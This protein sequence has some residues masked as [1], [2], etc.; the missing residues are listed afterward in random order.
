MKCI[1]CAL[2]VCVVSVSIGHTQGLTSE[3]R[4]FYLGYVEPSFVRQTFANTTNA[5]YGVYALV[6]SYDDAQVTVSYFDQNGSEH[7][8]GTYQIAKRRS[9]QIPLDLSKM[10]M[11]LP[12]EVAEYKACHLSAN[13][14]IAVTYFSTGACAG[15]SYL[16][17]TTAA[18]GKT[19]VIQSYRDN[20]DGIG[21]VMTHEPSAGYF[22]VV[23][24]FD[25]THVQII[26]SSTTAGGHAGVNC[27]N[28]ASGT[29]RP[30]TVSLS[31]C[32]CYLVRGALDGSDCDLSN[33]VVIADKPVAV[34]AG[35]ENV[36]TDGSDPNPGGKHLLDARDFMIEE[37]LPVEYWDT[38]GYIS[39]PFIDSQAPFNAGEG[40]EYRFFTG[41]IKELGSGGPGGSNV[42]INN[43]IRDYNGIGEYQIPPPQ[44]INWMSPID[45]Y[46]T[47]GTK[48]GVAMYDQRMHGGGAPYP[49]PSQLTIIPKSRWKSSYLF[50]VPNNPFEVL[51]GYY[52]NLI[53][54]RSDFSNR[55]LL[56]SINGGKLTP[57]PAGLATKKIYSVIPEFPEL[58]GY[59]FAIGPGS[60]YITADTGAVQPFM[61]YA[62]GNRA[63]DSDNNLGDM[64]SDDFFFSYASPSG[65][66]MHGDSNERLSVTVDSLCARWHLCIHDSRSKN[67][68]IK[69]IEIVDDI[70]GNRIKPGYQY[71]NVRFDAS[72]DPNGTRE[73]A[74]TGNDSVYCLDV[75]ISNPFDSA[76]A[77]IYIV[78]NEGNGRLI[79][80]HYKKPNITIGVVPNYP[81]QRDSIV[82]PPTRS[83]ESSCAT[84]S[85][86]NSGKP[87]EP[88][89]EVDNVTLL[90]SDGNYSITSIKPAL[91]VMLAPGDTLAV[92]VC[93]HPQNISTR[94]DS[95]P[96]YVDSL[97][98]STPCLR[99]PITLVGPLALP[100][101]HATDK[102]FGRVVIGSSKCDSVTV[103]NIGNVPFTLTDTVILQSVFHNNND[104]TW[105][106]SSRLN[107]N[108]LPVV[109][110]PGQFVRVSFCFTPS[111]K[112]YDSTAVD[113]KTDVQGGLKDS[114]KA[115]SGLRG[116]GIAPG[117][118]WD[119]DSSIRMEDSSITPISDRVR[120]LLIQTGTSKV[121]LRQ[122]LLEGQDAAEFQ[123]GAN[124]LNYY[125]LADLDIQ[126]GD[127]IW[128]DVDWQADLTIPYPNK[129][130]DRIALLVATFDQSGGGVDSTV[131]VLVRKFVSTGQGVPTHVAEQSAA[132]VQAFVVDGRL[133]VRI[134]TDFHDARLELFDLLGR[135]IWRAEAEDLPV[136]ASGYSVC[137]VPTLPSG[138]YSLRAVGIDGKTAVGKILIEK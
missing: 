52:V 29:P 107:K 57:L 77:P 59:T 26:P 19:Y 1:L 24:A 111:V 132:Q 116:T 120:V 45:C 79:E 56:L 124:K 90:H 117:L 18:L 74:L 41:V 20:S 48:I 31:R 86:V 114:V 32:Q 65:F 30:F 23:G 102:D 108:R 137:S 95:F 53:C 72:V 76:Y 105:D 123:L 21:G 135:R 12:G 85:Y 33:S 27:G 49:A 104:F 93:Y 43:H 134:P 10:R 109:L 83:G 35:H 138:M 9:V 64:D 78:D 55:K 113:W 92:T 8:S 22:M 44:V 68:G 98:V 5:Y 11:S 63:V 131:I 7:V 15:G 94:T 42:T 47:N 73:I 25:G 119:P 115:W 46:S 118:L 126:V 88:N 3:G 62:Y 69:A 28:G 122:T 70:N 6:S 110:Q 136:S 17:A 4:D 100:L 54:N 75:W 67:P 16:A 127:T 87:G 125:P 97:V 81:N 112:G 13:R 14:P 61:A 101:I 66:S 133:V 84:M 103:R 99:A 121:H 34:L 80:L 106:A 58:V 36:F 38:M 50:Y 96:L 37:M 82:F 39:I 89:I 2:I 128:V 40:D 129:F 130:R 60:Y 51:Q 91:P 71:H